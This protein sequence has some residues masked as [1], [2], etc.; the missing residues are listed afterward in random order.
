MRTQ[1]EIPDA[2]ILLKVWEEDHQFRK[3][4]DHSSKDINWKK[5]LII[6][7]IACLF[8]TFSFAQ[9][10]P[11]QSGEK[12]HYDI[13]YKYGFVMMKAGTANYQVNNTQLNQQPVVRTSLN[14]R[15][16]SFFD[17]I[18]KIR[19]TLYSYLDVKDLYPVYHKRH[20][21]EGST[22]YMEQIFF[23]ERNGNETK[24]RIKRETKTAVKLDTIMKT[25]LPGYDLLGIFAFARTLDYNS[26]NLNESFNI[27]TFVG[28]NLVNIK[29]RYKGQ[30]IVEKSDRLKYN[31]FR[32]E[33][34]ILDDAFDS[35]KNA[36][37]IWISNDLNR[38]PIKIKGKLKIGAAEVFLTSHE[39]LKYPFTSEIRIKRK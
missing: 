6:W 39:N 23:S 24:A 4:G 32:L 16:S 15:T 27:S 10:L 1:I 20:V 38:I 22:H 14:F 30:S 7:V 3:Q 21:H 18:Y 25:E 29:V 33:I 31:T 13:H 11:F 35:E 28:R 12:L 5:Y 26:L 19:D 9:D 36:M 8:P 34:D 2:E 37:E 17:K